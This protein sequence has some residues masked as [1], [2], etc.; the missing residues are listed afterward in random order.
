MLITRRPSARQ[1]RRHSRRL[2]ER[3]KVE[4]LEDRILLSADPGTDEAPVL[5]PLTMQQ[6]IVV[7]ETEDNAETPASSTDASPDEP[8]DQADGSDAETAET[9]LTADTGPD[10][11]VAAALTVVQESISIDLSQDVSQHERLTAESWQDE[12]LLWLDDAVSDLTINLGVSADSDVMLR[13]ADDVMLWL[14]GASFNDM[15]FARPAESLTIDGLSGSHRVQIES[16][17]LGNASFVLNAERITVAAGDV[18]T[19]AADISLNARYDF[20]TDHGSSIKVEGNPEVRVDGEIRTA[21]ALDLSATATAVVDLSEHPSVDTLNWSLDSDLSAHVAIGSGSAIDAHALRLDARTEIHATL[22]VEGVLAGVSSIDAVQQT[23]A[24]VAGGATIQAGD[25][26]VRIHATDR[27]HL[28]V[29]IS[30]ADNSL[31]GLPLL[32]GF[33]AVLSS[34]TASRDSHAYF[35]DGTTPA[36]LSGLN[37]ATAGPLEVQA[38]HLDGADGGLVGQVVSSL[39]GVH[40]TTL[41]QDRV[42][43]T[44][45]M[46]ELATSRVDVLALNASSLEADAR[47]AQLQVSGETVARVVDVSGE[48]GDVTVVARDVSALSAR[49]GDFAAATGDFDSLNLSA[50]IASNVVD[51][52]VRATIEGVDLDASGLAL[53]ADNAMEMLAETEA[54]SVQEPD[55]DDEEPDGDGYSLSMAGTYAWNQLQGAVHAEVID[56]S[57]NATGDVLVHATNDARVEARSEAGSQTTEGPGSAVGVGLAFNAI[58]WDVGNLAVVALDS[59]LGVDLAGGEV[60]AT[61]AAVERSRLSAGGDIGVEAASTLQ[62][63]ATVTNAAESVDAALYGATGLGAAA[64]LSSNRQRTSTAR[65]SSVMRPPIPTS[66]LV[67]SCASTRPMPRVCMPTPCWWRRRPPRQTVASVWCR[68]APTM[69]TCSART[70]SRG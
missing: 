39:V 45:D 68:S 9:V 41:T 10:A 14:S 1:L 70:E 35:G 29:H 56:S 60:L 6:S 7:D 2:Q 15:V 26:G 13:Q 34:I 24:G 43:A 47:V 53:H 38:R 20:F 30:T 18:M 67:A 23:H 63:G 11:D 57:I 40:Q 61:R 27:A 55:E 48:A 62:V 28:D 33:D 22:D 59:L 31:R 21:G 46:A 49:S 5:P 54:L 52:Q 12:A 65:K 32:S 8:A 25:G 69:R 66:T 17:D 44:V 37:A 58:G 16:L 64:I 36:V 42:R 50:A 3:S 51:R 4:R 19:S